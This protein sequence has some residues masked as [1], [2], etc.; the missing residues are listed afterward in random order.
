MHIP[1]LERLHCSSL[2]KIDKNS[3][4]VKLV[5]LESEKPD[6]EMWIEDEVRYIAS[7][8]YGIDG[9]DEFILYTPDT[10]TKDLDEEF[11]FWW[12]KSMEMYAPDT[13]TQYAIHNLATNEG[14]F[15]D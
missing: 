5:T 1:V 3:Y 12:P 9:G 11:L 8:P 13:L 2:E 10:K 6:G 15:G 7:T 14:F 4:K